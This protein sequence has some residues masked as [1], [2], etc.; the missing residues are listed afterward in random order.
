MAITI[1]TY[2]Q[3]QNDHY[4]GR[5]QSLIIC[6]YSSDRFGIDSWEYWWK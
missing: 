2:K 5:T 1:K 3:Q 4:M 6:I